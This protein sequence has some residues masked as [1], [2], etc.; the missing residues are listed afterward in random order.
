M[1]D[2]ILLTICQIHDKSFWSV[3]VPENNPERWN[4]LDQL[5]GQL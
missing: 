4:P 5:V 1:L 3:H 2:D